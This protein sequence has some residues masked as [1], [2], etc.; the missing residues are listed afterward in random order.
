[1]KGTGRLA[2]FVVAA[3]CAI[4]LFL[5]ASLL[6]LFPK[7]VLGGLLM[8]LGL[9]FLFE[10]VY[11]AY[12]KLPRLDYFVVILILVIIAA[13]GF[14]QGVA[15][16]LVAAVIFFVVNYSR[17]N[18]VK[19]ALSGV[20]F[21]SRVTREARQQRLLREL[22]EQ[23]YIL[24]LQ[25]FI[26]FGTANNLL[27]RVRN[28]VADPDRPAPRFILLEF[29]QVTGVDT[30][31]MLSFSKMRQLAK[32][33]GLALVFADISP[34]T[35][36]QFEAGGFEDTAEGPVHLFADL[37]HAL[38]WC[39]NRLLA[40]EGLAAGFRD[41]TIEDHLQVLLP[42]GAD[43]S[44]LIGYLEPQ[45]LE[46]GEF[47][48]R[49]G[50]PPEDLYFIESGQVTAQREIPDHE[51]IRLETMR[52]GHMLGEIGFYL[53]LERSASV[54]A[55]EPSKIYRLTKPALKRMEKADPEAALVFQEF[56]IELLSERVSH[57]VGTIDA[58][59]R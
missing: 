24:Q 3:V 1:V 57:M 37:D 10:W 11:E 58:L 48:I 46:A 40:G 39:E 7:V 55:D 38:E 18:V 12:F 30:T 47:L 59:Q 44:V 28:R 13:F 20:H 49:Q 9:S 27:E 16:G 41:E 25:G 22:G 21:K 4:T 32:S 50:D 19:Y 5:G 56:I 51:P 36:L 15:I 43:V 33:T 53:G 26:F 54:I 52:G 34:E 35:R 17:T 14:L 23:L 42:E 6:S 8:Y 29:R 31:A 45:E 2:A